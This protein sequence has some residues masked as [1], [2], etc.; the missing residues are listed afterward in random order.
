MERKIA[1]NFNRL[2]RVHE[3]YRR[4][5]TDRRTD[6]RYDIA[7][8]N[9]SSRSLKPGSSEET[10]EVICLI[11]EGSPGRSESTEGRICSN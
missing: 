5:T 8:V 7:N 4:K 6:G 9:V 11:R 1:E 2:S 10:V 3:R